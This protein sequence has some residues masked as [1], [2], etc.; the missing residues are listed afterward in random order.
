MYYPFILTGYKKMNKNLGKI[1]RNVN[2]KGK[3]KENCL[4]TILLE[5]YVFKYSILDL[6]F[7]V[8]RYTVYF[9][10][11]YFYYFLL[12]FNVKKLDFLRVIF[13]FSFM[14]L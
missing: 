4:I 8:T 5:L 12:Y 11:Y 14:F 2:I 1:K 7:F 13:L 9:C 6:S 3:D 10:Y